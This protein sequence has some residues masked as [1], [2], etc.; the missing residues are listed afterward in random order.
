VINAKAK[1]VGEEG[2]SLP[3][4]LKIHAISSKVVI[5]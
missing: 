3:L 2:I 4:K 5:I 1:A